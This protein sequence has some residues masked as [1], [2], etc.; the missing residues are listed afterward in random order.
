MDESGNIELNQAPEQTPQIS[1]RPE[2]NSPDVWGDRQDDQ[3]FL[4]SLE[5]FEG[6]NE[7]SD[8]LLL[9]CMADFDSH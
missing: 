5:D 2:E 3:D 7:I 4:E 9:K 1:V 6:Q 8:Q